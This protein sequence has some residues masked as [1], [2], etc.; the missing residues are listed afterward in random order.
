MFLYFFEEMDIFC[1]DL[2]ALI[3]I[4]DFIAL[5]GISHFFCCYNCYPYCSII[6][7]YSDLIAL[8]NV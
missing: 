5:I 6:T 7:G 8:I 2:I 4:S 3:G 1:F